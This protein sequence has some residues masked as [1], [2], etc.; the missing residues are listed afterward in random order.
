MTIHVHID[1]AGSGGGA[2][3]S[4]YNNLENK[5]KINNVELHGNKS[6]AQLFLQALLESGVNIKTINGQTILGS[7]NL[8]IGN[9]VIEPI[10]VINEF[11]PDVP[12]VT[13]EFVSHE[14][15][16]YKFKMNHTSGNPWDASE[17]DPATDEE[18]IGFIVGGEWPQMVAGNITP[19]Q[20]EPVVTTNRY[21]IQTTGD[22]TDL[23]SGTSMLD[24]IK[25]TLDAKMGPFIADTFVSTGMNLVDPSQYLS[26]LNRKAYY[27]PV[28]ACAWGAYGTTEENNG[29][30]IVSSSTPVGVYFS[31]T[32]PTVLS[33][34]SECEYHTNNSVKYY[35]PD[36]AGW[37]IIIMPDDVVPA[38]HIAWS[39]TK[40]TVPGTFGNTVKSIGTA[41]SA[42]HAWGLA[43]IV[44]IDRSVYDELNFVAGKGYARIDRAL[45][46][47]LTWTVT[48][49]DEGD[50]DSPSTVRHYVFT[51]SVSGMKNNGL[52]QCGS[53]SVDVSGTSL[54]IESTSITNVEDLVASFGQSDYIYYEKATVSESNISNASA[55]RANMVNDYGLS[56]FL[57]NG[58]LV[59]VPAYVTEEFYQ[60]G[61]DPLY[62][63]ADYV[64]GELNQVVA[65]AIAYLQG[66]IN[67]ILYG[68][69]H[70][71]PSLTVQHLKVCRSMDA[72]IK[73]GN[74][75]LHGAGA[76]TMIPQFNGQEYFDETNAVWYKA[77]YTG[78]QPTSAAWKLITN[79]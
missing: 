13:R 4:N 11:D 70:G 60:S 59:G 19:K 8:K 21:A 9:N 78:T 56:Y 47:S 63:T 75:Y 18:I 17:V 42:V 52:W 74:F 54:R 36:T 73:G 62:N 71:L 40:D 12:Y 7:G 26:I 55:L 61:K 33:Y 1:P 39:N 22:S 30:I 72:Y 53:G 27:F 32:K 10:P 65:G 43:G 46:S 50:V 15:N 68:I 29:L 49:Y 44:G 14:G 48:S 57:Y 2:G 69:E 35:I 38:C 28:P 67:G 37:L 6:A 3:T 24:S 20:Q 41:L 66:Q 76:P 23:L 58:E 77:S 31:E 16:F 51:A 45:L 64:H 25:G 79:A 34:G 5:P